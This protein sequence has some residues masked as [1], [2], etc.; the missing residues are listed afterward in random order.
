MAGVELAK[1]SVDVAGLKKVITQLEPMFKGGFDNLPR[2]LF[3]VEDKVI[4]YATNGE[5]YTKITFECEIINKGEFVVSGT[6]L[7][8]IV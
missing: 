7:A 4:A 3:Q 8:K 6:T 1:F 5:A 2:V